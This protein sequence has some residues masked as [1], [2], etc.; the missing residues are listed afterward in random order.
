MRRRAQ[1][2]VT[3][4]CPYTPDMADG[5]GSTAGMSLRE[6]KKH[7]TR[8]ALLTAADHLFA[9]RGYD[10]VTVAE[11]ADA[12]NIS[13]KTLFTYF[14]SKEDIDVG[15]MLGTS[16]P[17]GQFTLLDYVAAQEI[18]AQQ[19]PKRGRRRLYNDRS[20]FPKGLAAVRQTALAKPRQD[21]SAPPPACPE[22][23]APTS[24]RRS[25][26]SRR[27]AMCS[28]LS[29]GADTAMPL[30]VSPR[31]ARTMHAGATTTS[32]STS[33]PPMRRRSVSTTVWAFVFIVPIRNSVPWPCRT[34]G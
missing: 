5:T 28:L 24:L 26:V 19:D 11:I 1:T 7:L 18:T 29:H 25:S 13:V 2:K 10:N 33:T 20:G 27:S 30:P 23:R 22:R 21:R 9:A 34:A 4:V 14:A 6:R 3:L 31:C 32:S 15:M 17:M 16:Y 8:Q 12:A